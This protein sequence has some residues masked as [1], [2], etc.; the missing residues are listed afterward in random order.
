MKMEKG[1]GGGE[2]MKEREK[3]EKREKRSNSRKGREFWKGATA[4]RFFNSKRKKQRERRKLGIDGGNKKNKGRRLGG[5]TAREK[6]KSR[7]Q[8]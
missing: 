6:H 1:L 4:E 8:G 7:E 5:R 2:K 3:K